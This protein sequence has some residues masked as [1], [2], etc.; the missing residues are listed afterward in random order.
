MINL[1]GMYGMYLYFALTGLIITL[2]VAAISL[3]R[4]RKGE[5]ALLAWTVALGRFIEKYHIVFLMLIFAVFLISRLFMIDS[6]PNGFHVDELGMAVDSKMLRFHG[7]DRWGNRYPVYLLN[8]G[9]GQSALYA[10]TS[11]FLLSFMPSGFYAMRLPAVIYGALCFFATYFIGIE[12]TENKGYALMGPILVTTLP[13]YIMSE[14][15]GLDCNLFLS[16]AGVMLCFIIRA[17]RHSGWYDWILAGIATGAT[18][19]T[20][21]L[22]YL[23]LPIFLVLAGIYMVRTGKI[24]LKHVIFFAVPLALLA[25][26]LILYQLVN[27]HILEPFTLGVSDLAP[28]TIEREED[29]G[30]SYILPNLAFF[31]PMFLGGEELT[32][33]VFREFGTFYMFLIPFVVAGLIISVRDTAVSF[34]KREFSPSAI[35]LA[36]FIASVVVTLVLKGPNV[37]RV[38][39]IY[40]PSLLFIVIALH[41]LFAKKPLVL[42]WTAVWTAAS[43]VFFMYFYLFVQNDVYGYHL[44]HENASPA[45]A[46]LRTEAQYLKDADTHIYLQTYGDQGFTNMML[47]YFVGGPDDV[48]DLNAE[49]YGNISNTIPEIDLNENAAYIVSNEWPHIVSY[50]ISEGFGY[51]QSLPGY[52]ILFRK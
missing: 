24:T 34:K 41:R 22:S 19:Y 26:P 14:R 17:I 23:V 36:F 28:L 31:G 30:L 50:L 39:E 16:L 46:I 40:M 49:G 37:N 1:N 3:L 15:W 11:A 35:V 42:S 33:N 21:A 38:N 51:D 5:T 27:L 47:Y 44:L 7:T 4:G 13:E 8:Y 48:C 10:Y 18:L 43:F 9:G 2:A 29:M 32:Y 52:S 20:Y 45:K 12:L 6:F 25:M